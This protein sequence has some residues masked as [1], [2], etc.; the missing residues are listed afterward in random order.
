MNKYSDKSDYEINKAVAVN[1]N[2]TDSV[3][4]K[5]GRIYI[6]DGDRGA[7]VSF[8]P[9]NNPADAW[10]IINEYGISLIY[11]EREFQFATNDGNIECSISNPLKAAMIIF[12]MMKDAENES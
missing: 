10:P 2:G 5:F 3:L 12:L 7:M 4:E 6:S 1:I 11:Q 8:S 9:C